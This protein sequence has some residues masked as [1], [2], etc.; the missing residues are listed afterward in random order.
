MES[1]VCKFNKSG[2]CKFRDSCLK[3]HENAVCI[4]ENC[5]GKCI[6]RHPKLCRY[7]AQHNY[8]KFGNLCKYKHEED[9]SK[10]FEERIGHLEEAL[11]KSLAEIEILK[12]KLQTLETT[13]VDQ[14]KLDGSNSN[15]EV[16][17]NMKDGEVQTEK[18]K[19][20]TCE[21]CKKSFKNARGLNIHMK[22]HDNIAQIDGNVTLISSD[23]DSDNFN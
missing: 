13:Q 12:R 3:R 4:E 11:S 7:F 5:N 22:V 18:D 19:N 2:Y 20:G 16:E 21:I 1:E 17:N 23:G 14:A 10:D 9:T 8:C 15:K 6:R